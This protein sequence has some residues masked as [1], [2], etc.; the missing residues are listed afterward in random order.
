MKVG[1]EV[2]EIDFSHVPK[3]LGHP[4]GRL[5]PALFDLFLEDHGK[6]QIE[7]GYRWPYFS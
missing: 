6:C 4:R 3:I 1:F 7:V 5:I 2:Q